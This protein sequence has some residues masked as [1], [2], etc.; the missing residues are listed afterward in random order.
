MRNGTSRVVIRA[1][2]LLVVCGSALVLGPGS[3]RPA[4]RAARAAQR[5]TFNPVAHL[6]ASGEP[7]PVCESFKSLCRDAF[8]TPGDPYVGHDEP[9]VAFRS[10]EPGSANDITYTVRLPRD[11]PKR[12]KA[13]GSGGVWNFELRPTFWLGLTLCDTESAPEFTQTCTP[14][15]DANNLVGTDPNAADYIGKHPGNAFMELQFYGPGYVPQFEGFG[16]DAR[17]YC[18]A[19]TIDSLTEDQNTHTFNTADC[20][21]YILGGQEPINWAYITKSGHSQAPADPLF[22]GT[23]DNPNFAAVNPDYPQD[24]LMNPG[25]RIRIHLHD[26][27]AG[28][29]A[30]LTDLDTHRSGSMTASIAN[31]FA[32]VLFTPGDQNACQSAPYAFHAEYSTAN[33]RGNTWSAHTT[34][35]SYSDEIGHF[36]HCLELDANFNCAVAG[37]D[38]PDGLDADDVFC[39]PGSD[40]TL[41]H[42]NGCFQADLDF[43]GPSYQ[44]DWPGTNPNVHQDRKFHMEPVIFSSPTTNGGHQYPNFQFEADMPAF[45]PTCDTTTGAGCTN[46]PPG[47]EFYPFYSTRLDRVHGHGRHHETVCNWQEGGDF[48]PGTVNDY[49]GSSAEFGSLLL[50]TYPGAGFM[51]VQRYE[52]FNSGTLPNTCPASG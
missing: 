4:V 40:S 21:N 31:G 44:P 16:C 32:H 27:A 26:T 41:I 36:E 35:V 18:A 30:D 47:A 49:G 10:S 29:R 28:Y 8:K 52:N 39:V 45:E 13:D 23:F 25:D 1:A 34:N 50:T 37:S 11:P 7:E 38:D 19:M 51:P 22:T 14:D 42:I 5:Q 48:I 3:A 17:H 33:A 24:L 43:D 12:P 9:S 46:P 15:S 20:D 6:T 2:V